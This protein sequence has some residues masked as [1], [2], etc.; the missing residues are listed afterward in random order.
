MKNLFYKLI[1]RCFDIVS[2]LLAIIILSPLLLLITIINIFATK[3]V[4][5]YID[6]RVGRDGKQFALLKFCS[7]YKDANTNPEKYLTN[8]QIEQWKKER[9][10]TDDPRITPFGRFIRKS[11]LDELPQLFCILIGTMSVVGPRPVVRNEID[12][13]Y[14]EEEK[15]LLLS[16][17][18]GLISNWGVNGRN[19][20]SYENRRRQE[21]ELDY[22]KKRS[23]WYDFKLMLKSVGVVISEKG[24]Q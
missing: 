6:R 13:H 19:L 20:V 7:M 24:A 4:P 16:V 14:T 3:G 2:S 23:L 10:V 22:F 8:D 1:K 15:K 21:L 9:K 17:R 18:P 12:Q 5:I 11:S